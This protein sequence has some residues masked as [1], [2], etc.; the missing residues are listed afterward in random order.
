M[1]YEFKKLSAV[2]A[3]ETPADTAH[4]LIEEDGVIKRTPKSE[5]GGVK[6]V[7]WNDLTDRPFYE[8]LGYG[9]VVTT[10]VGKL[11]GNNLDAVPDWKVGNTYTYA[12]DGVDYSGVVEYDD[13]D[14][15]VLSLYDNDVTVATLYREGMD[16][17]LSKSKYDS[18]I[19][20][21]IARKYIIAHQLD[22]RYIADAVYPKFFFDYCYTSA[23]IA[24][25]VVNSTTTKPLKKLEAGTLIAVSFTE[26]N[27]A[28]SSLTLN[29]HGTGARTLSYFNDGN[30]AAGV[31]LFV[32][33][34]SNWL[35]IK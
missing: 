1:A 3:V 34:G 2:E 28:T 26:G 18:N 31:Y 17:Y 11:Y 24:N 32:F 15:S 22:E 29:F 6:S 16:Y 5:V 30:I 27:T 14:G 25:K 21:T 10:E 12:I 4:V 13:T 23:N 9:N 20:H 19:E 35:R 8:E 33:N 7:S